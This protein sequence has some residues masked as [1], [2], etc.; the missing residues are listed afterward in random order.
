MEFLEHEGKSNRQ[1]RKPMKFRTNDSNRWN[2]NELKIQRFMH[3]FQFVPPE[4]V[5][6]RSKGLPTLRPRDKARK[7]EILRFGG[8]I[9][10][11][12][13]GGRGER[14]SELGNNRGI[15]ERW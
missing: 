1:G 5:M 9:G 6:A 8:I 15:E 14:S 4:R 12:K 11:S 2:S 13:S 10:G 3:R 7:S